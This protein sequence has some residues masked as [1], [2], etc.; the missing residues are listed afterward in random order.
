MTEPNEYNVRVKRTVT[1]G[2]P[3]GE[4]YRAWQEPGKMLGFLAGQG[5][6]DVLDAR[7]SPWGSMLPGM[8]CGEAGSEILGRRENESVA[9]RATGDG[10]CAYT[11]TVRFRPA[12]NDLGTEVSLELRSRV[13]GGRAASGLAALFG[14]SPEEL[15][16]RVLHNFKQL[17]ETGEV[18]TNQ[19]PQGRARL[20]A[21]PKNGPLL[22]AGAA[23]AALSV[24]LLARRT[25]DAGLARQDRERRY[26]REHEHELDWKYGRSARWMAGPVTGRAADSP[27]HG[28]A[29]PPVGRTTG[30]AGVRE[31]SGMDYGH[32]YGRPS[33]SYPEAWD[34]RIEESR[35]D[36][37]MGGGI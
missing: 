15:A 35:A 27:E 21:R 3:A 8:A 26:D 19:G 17:A 10:A 16:S 9:W 28:P 34:E 23:V 33:G 4:L 37:T 20:L 2:R 18:A 36:R 25:G 31:R 5:S 6:M 12:P 30:R 24:L 32:M 14:R 11:G 1:I 7:R 22:L 13:P 29:H